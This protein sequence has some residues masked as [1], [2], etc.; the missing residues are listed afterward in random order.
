MIDTT[1]QKHPDWGRFCYEHF[2]NKVVGS[3]L[4]RIVFCRDWA[5]VPFIRYYDSEAEIDKLLEAAK[6][7]DAG[8]TILSIDR[9]QRAP[10]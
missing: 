6:N 8:I 5:A 7:P 3:N 9:F 4:I 1:P 10:Q 2:I